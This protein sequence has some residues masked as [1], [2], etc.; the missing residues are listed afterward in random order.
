[1][2]IWLKRL[3]NINVKRGQQRP[4]N[5][6][7]FILFAI[8]SCQ[9]E[10]MLGG[11]KKNRKKRLDCNIRGVVRSLGNNQNDVISAKQNPR[12]NVWN[13]FPCSFIITSKII[14][15]LLTSESFR[16]Y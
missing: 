13:N 7:C 5:S 3:E 2:I 1:M 9:R 14:T 6:V 11:G 8:L 15:I 10:S 4:K 16:L 12:S